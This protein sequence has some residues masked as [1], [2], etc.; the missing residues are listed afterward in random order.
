MTKESDSET[1]QSG[2]RFLE[3]NATAAGEAMLNQALR[4]M[5]RADEVQH[6]QP[7]RMV[8]YARAAAHLAEA[9][10]ALLAGMKGGHL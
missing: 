3:A 9:A 6:T 8:P 10:G 7:D 5:R 1:K 2:A 4:F